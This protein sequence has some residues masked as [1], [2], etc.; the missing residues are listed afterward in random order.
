MNTLIKRNSCN[1]MRPAYNRLIDDMFNFGFPTF[2]TEF[3]TTK[4]I[5]RSVPTANISE[6]E[7]AFKID[8]AAPGYE[9]EDLKLT[10]EDKGKTLKVKAEIENSTE[11]SDKEN[12][13]NNGIF[14]CEHSYSSFE[15]SFSLPE[16]VDVEKISASYK[17]GILQ[18]DIPKMQNKETEISKKIDIL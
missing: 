2:L 3:P 12:K 17:R 4:Q 5:L 16:N 10:L 1:S 18:I 13:N 8:L 9:K 7:D 15:R 6:S 11:E 14:H